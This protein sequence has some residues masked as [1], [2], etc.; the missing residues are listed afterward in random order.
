M[1]GIFGNLSSA[2]KKLGAV[3]GLIVGLTALG[4]VAAVF[5]TPSNQ[6]YA[7]DQ[8]IPFSHKLHAGDNKIDCLYCHSEAAKSKHAS[9]P[10][11]NTCMNCHRVVKTDSPLIQTLHKHVEENKPIEWIRVHELPDFVVF[12][13]KRHVKAG[14]SCQTCHGAVEQMDVMVQAE[15][16]TMGWCLNCHRGD[17]TPRNVLTKFHPEVNDPRGLQ[18]APTNCNTC[19]Y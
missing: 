16:L 15:P 6:G 5:P 1:L 3:F 4:V 9:V 11:L 12:N 13:H 19:H 8:P 7:P 18:V 14:V 17:T 10:P 2:Q